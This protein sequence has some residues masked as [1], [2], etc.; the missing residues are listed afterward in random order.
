M[1]SLGI[2]VRQY[3]KAA[4]LSVRELAAAVGVS[5]SSLSRLE[6]GALK[7]TRSSTLVALAQCLGVTLDDLVHS[8]APP[9][10]LPRAKTPE[11]LVESYPFPAYVTQGDLISAV[12]QPLLSLTGYSQD[13][14]VGSQVRYARFFYPDS[15]LEAEKYLG[16]T[17]DGVIFAHTI[18]SAPVRQDTFLHVLHICTEEAME[19]ALAPLYATSTSSI[20][21]VFTRIQSAL[22]YLGVRGVGLSLTRIPGWETYLFCHYEFVHLTAEEALAREPAKAWKA[23]RIELERCYLKG[24]PYDRYWNHTIS[25]SPL[26]DTYSPRRIV[27]VPVI[28]GTLGVG[29]TA[30]LTPAGFVPFLRS[31]AQWLDNRFQ[32]ALTG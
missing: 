27:D 7:E 11:E 19:K 14:L 21:E 23:D 32:T 28:G 20:E 17:R 13:E 10:Q 3:R 25:H 5:H 16:V 31:I 2:R 9:E 1:S 15:R 6:R 12:N 24:I 30:D 4:G 8:D 29:W 26:P 18:V 22:R